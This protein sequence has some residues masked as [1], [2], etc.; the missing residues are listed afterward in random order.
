M[1]VTAVIGAQWGDEGK[2]KL[3]HILSAEHDIILR[4]Q[5]GSNAGHTVISQGQTYKFKL[6]PSGVLYDGKLALLCDGVVVNVVTL[7]EEIKELEARGHFKGELKISRHAHLVLPLHC[8]QDEYFEE[9]KGKNAIGTTRRGIGPAYADKYFRVGLRAGDMLNGSFGERVRAM[10]QRKN[11][12]FTGYYGKE[13]MDPDAVW[14]QVEPTVEVLAPLVDDTI[15]IVREAVGADRRILCEGAQGTLLDIDYGTYPYVTSSHPVSGGALLGTG[16]S[17]RNLSR[18]V[19]VSKAY[20]TRVGAGPFPTE[21]LGPEGDQMREAGVE[22]GTVTGRPRRCGWLDLPLLK[23][24]V[25]LSG[26]TELALT[27]TD[28]LDELD[29]IKVCVGYERDGRR[30]DWLDLDPH[31][32]ESC[33]PV[34]E[35]LPGWRTETTAIRSEQDLPG[36]FRDYVQFIEQQLDLPISVISVGADAGAT[37]FRS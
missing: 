35:L 27:K 15:R 32:L 16:L 22:Y 9:A 37:I 13:Q 10:T 4:Y 33:T 17:W 12:L 28:V 24:A 19:G 14:E 2:G 31:E 7:A 8:L 34:Y 30:V 5:G 6:I 1:S 3:A 21:E 18:V 25:E 29:Q 11:V 23:Y 26:F 36:Q 20:T